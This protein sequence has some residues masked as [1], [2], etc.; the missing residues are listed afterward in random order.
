MVTETK[1]IT[2]N[3]IAMDMA[4]LPT[5]FDAKRKYLDLSIPSTLFGRIAK[6]LKLKWYGK[7]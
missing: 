7:D 4:V 6:Q 2:S 1:N 5:L 3:S